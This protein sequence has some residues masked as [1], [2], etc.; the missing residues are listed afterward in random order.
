MKTNYFIM[1]IVLSTFCA[2]CDTHLKHIRVERENIE[3]SW[4]DVENQY[5][6]RMDI[7]PNIIRIVKVNAPNEKET[8]EKVQNVY[9]QAVEITV[10]AE[11]ITDE[12]TQLNFEEGQER[13][14]LKD[15]YCK[16]HNIQLEYFQYSL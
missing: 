1:L 6:R 14:R 10:D 5:H 2:S 12:Q 4:S 11:N 7:I 9:N 8:I 16:S 13:D 3:I 15:E